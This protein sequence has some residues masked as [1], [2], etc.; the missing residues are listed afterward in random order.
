MQLYLFLT[1]VARLKVQAQALAD[2]NLST[3]GESNFANNQ[4]EEITIPSKVTTIG[5]KAFR[6]NNLT[7]VIMLS[8]VPPTVD[9][10]CFQ[11]AKTGN[12]QLSITGYSCADTKIVIPNS[13][14]G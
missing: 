3:I 8:S 7:K 11:A 12:G 2:S 6:N 14:D 13:L 10:K 9:D 1:N 4:L 5:A